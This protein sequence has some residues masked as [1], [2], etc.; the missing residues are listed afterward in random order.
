MDYMSHFWFKA[1]QYRTFE[2]ARQKKET[3]T[4]VHT[5]MHARVHKRTQPH[6]TGSTD[7]CR[8]F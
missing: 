2:K 3:K 5:Y 7:L 8:D 4:Y 6:A 1:S